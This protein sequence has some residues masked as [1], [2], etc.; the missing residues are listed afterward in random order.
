MAGAA[1]RAAAL[2]LAASRSGAEKVVLLLLALD[3]AKAKDLL[4]RFDN[5]EIALLMR[6]AE[7]LSAA[8]GDELARLVEDFEAAFADGAVALA[9][10]SR[11]RG[12]FESVTR[13]AEAS[14]SPAAKAP[15][16]PQV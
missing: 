14:A 7:R 16:R 9:A 15:A 10:P 6:T 3:T 1:P 8:T 4:A 13:E 2:G 11:V 12:L 5:N